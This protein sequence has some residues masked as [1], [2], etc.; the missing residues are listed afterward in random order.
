VM[1][2]RDVGFWHPFSFDMKREVYRAL[3]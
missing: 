1:A 3:A 2:Q